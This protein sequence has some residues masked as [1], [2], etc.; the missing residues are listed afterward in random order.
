MTDKKS[1]PPSRS[2]APDVES[3]ELKQQRDAFVHTFFKKGV[4][5]TE[6][7]LRENER[8]R[9][10]AVKLELENAVLRTQ[11]KSDQAIRDAL[12]KIEQLEKE[13]EDLLSQFNAA[14]E[15]TTRFTGR[16]AEIE[17]E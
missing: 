14:E 9:N 1:R 12:T 15:V 3:G 6:E 5:F 11:L 17:E 7:L 4:E 16:Y 13:K 10:Q 2:E 8:L